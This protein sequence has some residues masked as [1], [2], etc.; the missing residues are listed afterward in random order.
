MGSRGRSA[1]FADLM[2]D[3]VPESSTAVERSELPPEAAM[4]SHRSAGHVALGLL[5]TARPH[6][7]IKN[8]FVLAPVVFAK[9]LFVASLVLRA[10]GAFLVFCVLAGAVYTM[11]DIAD[12]KADR[13]H[14]VKRYR[15]IASGLISRNQAVLFAVTLVALGLGGAAFLPLP[16]FLT[17]AGYFLMNIAYS[18]GLKR[19]PYLDVGIIAAGFVLRVMAGGYGTQINVSGYLFACTALLALFLG[20]GKRRHELSAAEVGSKRKQR[21]VLDAYSARGLDIALAVT[22]LATI[23]TYLAYT[24]NPTTQAFFHSTRLWMT[25]IFVILGVLRFIYLVRNRPTA[26]SPT[27]EMLKDGPFVGV[28]LCWAMVVIW[29]V[30]NLQPAG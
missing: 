17:A 6:Q 23:F 9:D 7:W 2:V 25:S 20:F 28:V 11:N 14:P 19:V 24:L 15:P 22:A 29:T 18:F 10:A 26:E 12:A 5:W 21:K 13:A 30:Y 16:F 3:Y 27:Q 4:P 1:K 8:V